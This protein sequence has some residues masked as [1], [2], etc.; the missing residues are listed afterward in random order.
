MFPGLKQYP[1]PK[2]IPIVFY[3]PDVEL[4]PYPKMPPLTE[5]AIRLKAVLCS[6]SGT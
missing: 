5:I 1:I 4:T 2:T 3:M 6:H